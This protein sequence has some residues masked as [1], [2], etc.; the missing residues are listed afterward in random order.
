MTTTQLLRTLL[1]TATLTS[2][3]IACKKTEASPAN[4]QTTPDT[5]AE[6]KAIQQLLN[7]YGSALNASDAAAAAALFTQD[8]AFMAPGSP[9]ATGPAQIRGAFNG[10][11]GAVALKLQFTPAQIVVASSSYAFATSTSSG[12]LTPKATGQAVAS[13]YRELW[14]FTKENGQW[15]IARY[16]FNQPQ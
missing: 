10:L 14:A 2:A 11:F 9:T 15:K 13:S 3:T 8:G 1:L 4:T 16:L 6:Q 12:T 7:A 5:P